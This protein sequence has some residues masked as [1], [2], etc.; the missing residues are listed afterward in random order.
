MTTSKSDLP[1]ELRDRFWE[2]NLAELS[3]PQHADLII[4]RILTRGTWSDFQW[5]RSVARDDALADW[6]V[7]HKGRGLDRRHLNFYRFVF[8]IP[9][10]TVDG[11]L[12]DPARKIWDN[13]LG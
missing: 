6:I 9:K 12:R 5:L 3:W 13:R 8:R 11:W 2:Y 1:E 4:G 7:R 10:A